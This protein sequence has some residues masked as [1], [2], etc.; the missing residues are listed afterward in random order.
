MRCDLSFI[1]SPR[2]T[3]TSTV[4]VEVTPDSAHT[5]RKWLDDEWIYLGCEPLRPSGKVLLL[6]KILGVVDAYGYN[7]LTADTDKTKALAEQIAHALG[8]PHITVD[9]PGLRVGY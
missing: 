2:D 5:A 1:F 9:L 7:T 4:N 8:R 6:D 3:I